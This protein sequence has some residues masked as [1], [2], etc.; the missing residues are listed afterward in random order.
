MDQVLSSDGSLPHNKDIYYLSIK[1]FY[2]AEHSSVLL[3]DF[4]G[5]LTGTLKLI[6]FFPY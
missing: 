5:L 2:F 3:H 6:C 4:F 1:S